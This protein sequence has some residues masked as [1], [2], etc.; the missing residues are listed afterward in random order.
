L[1]GEGAEEGRRWRSRRRRKGFHRFGGKLSCT[2]GGS[3]KWRV[4][5][6]KM[7]FER[8]EERSVVADPEATEREEERSVV[9]DPEATA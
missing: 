9:A 8:E 6:V 1:W 2:S 3:R 4:I 7:S 5:A